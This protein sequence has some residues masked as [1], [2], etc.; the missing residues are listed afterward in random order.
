MDATSGNNGSFSPEDVTKLL[1]ELAASN[2]LLEAATEQVATLTAASESNAGNMASLEKYQTYITSEFTTL[3]DAQPAY[4]KE[5]IRAEDFADNPLK[6]IKMIE[7]YNIMADKIFEEKG[8]KAPP[9]KNPTDTKVDQN[10]KKIEA[11]KGARAQIIQYMK[12][13]IT[14]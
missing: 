3:Y 14:D 11:P 2:K 8:G 6:G 12:E 1:G 10:N 5:V 4:V 7:N 13:Q 9:A